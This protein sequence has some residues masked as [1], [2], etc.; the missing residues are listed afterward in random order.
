MANPRGPIRC[1]SETC[2]ARQFCVHLGAPGFR[3][4]PWCVPPLA[5]GAC[6]AGTELAPYCNG[7]ED[8][9]CVETYDPPPAV[10]RCIDIPPECETTITC[11]CAI[12][13]CG[14]GCDYVLGR[15]AYCSGAPDAP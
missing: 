14:R 4:V 7:S 1:G 13:V 2:G 15:D 9:G 8:G 3:P 11:A 12:G 6:P 10:P 5:G